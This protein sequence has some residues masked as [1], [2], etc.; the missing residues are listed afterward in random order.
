MTRRCA[1]REGV[2]TNLNALC[3]QRA[4]LGLTIAEG[5]PPPDAGQ[6]YLLTPGIYTEAQIA[7]WP[8]RESGGL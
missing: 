5:T 1:T 6:G 7:G 4:L 2:P 8:S 3:A